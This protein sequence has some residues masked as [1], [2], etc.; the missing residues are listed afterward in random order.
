MHLRHL[1]VL[2]A[3]FAAG[4]AAANQNWTGFHVGAHAGQGRGSSDVDVTLGG[5]WSIESQGLRD[6][7][8]SSFSTGLDPEGAAWGVQLGY[9][10]ALDNG[11]VLGGEFDYSQLDLDD[12]RQTGLQ[13]VPTF[14]SLSYDFGNR[15]E[16]DNQLSLRATLGYAFDRHLLYLT[17][18][19]TRVDALAQASMRSNGGYD[20]LGRRSDTLDGSVFGAGYEY[21]FGNRWSLR[22]EYLHSDV[23]ALR[24]DTAYQPG[25]TFLDPPYT[26]SVR[27]DLD[28]GVLRIGVN[29]TF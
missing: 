23:D 5:A 13:P 18:G 29:Y 2:L 16:L 25:S 11:V 28:F 8:T 20:K 24:Y 21:A 3:A 4:D 27:Q 9:R 1:V 26:E 12:R 19:W 10:F 7:V 22:A 6:H 17:A 14:G 15:I